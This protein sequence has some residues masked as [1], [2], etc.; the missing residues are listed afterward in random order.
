MAASAAMHLDHAGFNF[1][2]RMGINHQVEAEQRGCPVGPDHKKNTGLRNSH[3]MHKF[4]AHVAFLH[5]QSQGSKAEIN[6]KSCH[7]LQFD[8]DLAALRKWFNSHFASLCL[9]TEGEKLWAL[10]LV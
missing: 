1:P 6:E 2:G 7:L 8:F 9:S 5:C 10:L 4:L 3:L